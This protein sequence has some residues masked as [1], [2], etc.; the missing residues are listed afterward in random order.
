MRSDLRF[1]HS[2]LKGDS[3]SDEETAGPGR[4]QSGRRRHCAVD[5]VNLQGQQP[6]ER[7]DAGQRRRSDSRSYRSRPSSFSDLSLRRSVPSNQLMFSCKS[8]PR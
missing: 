8:S 3:F 5:Q 6:P 2:G 4:L 7:S 1:D